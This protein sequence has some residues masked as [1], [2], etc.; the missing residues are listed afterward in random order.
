MVVIG[1]I[2]LEYT[3]ERPLPELMNTEGFALRQWAPALLVA[4]AKEI[5]ADPE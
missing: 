4:L 2:S 1:S 3:R 5:G